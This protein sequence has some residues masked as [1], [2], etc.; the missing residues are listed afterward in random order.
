MAIGQNRGAHNPLDASVGAGQLHMPR[1]ISK[2][3]PTD[4]APH[5]AAMQSARQ[6]CYLAAV[7][8]DLQSRDPQPTYPPSVS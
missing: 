1:Q 8:K 2:V 5:D 6:T 3:P 7:H 4:M